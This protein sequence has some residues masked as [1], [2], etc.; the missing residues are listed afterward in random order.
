[1]LESKRTAVCA[2]V[3]KVVS[4]LEAVTDIHILD[5]AVAILTQLATTLHSNAQSDC[6]SE[7]QPQLPPFVPVVYI[8][9]YIQ[10]SVA[11]KNE[12]QVQFQLCWQKTENA[13]FSV[14]ICNVK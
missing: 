1:M 8:Y 14:S 2:Q 10:F 7:E 6:K 11:E 4:E 13:A 12:I 5:H 9:I 3:K